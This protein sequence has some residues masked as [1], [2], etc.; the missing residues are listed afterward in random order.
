MD[1]SNID[2]EEF[3]WTIHLLQIGGLKYKIFLLLKYIATELHVGSKKTNIFHDLA[4]VVRIE[5][6]L[7]VIAEF[8][9]HPVI[10]FI[11][12]ML[13]LYT[14]CYCYQRKESI[15]RW[16]HL[17]IQLLLSTTTAALRIS[18]N[19]MWYLSMRLCCHCMNRHSHQQMQNSCNVWEIEIQSHVQRH[20]C[21][22]NIMDTGRWI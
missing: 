15:E 5:T 18:P 6:I 4:T 3:Y 19:F 12:Q 20:N 7:F 16:W 9:F 22:A 13:Q 10:Y 14:A 11:Q 2:I 1:F 8:C 21:I 17:A